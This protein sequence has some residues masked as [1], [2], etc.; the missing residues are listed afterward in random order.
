[1][2]YSSQGKQLC[3]DLFSSTLE[4]SLDPTNR[5]YKLANSL[6]WAEIERIYNGR[7]RNRHC[8]GGNKPARMVI[9]ALIIKHKMNL[10]D[11]ET[12]Q[13]ISE[14]PYMQ[15]FVGLELFTSNPI[16]DSSLFVHIRK[17][18]DVESFNEMTLAI[19]EEES[20]KIEAA[21][22]MQDNKKEDEDE[23]DKTEADDDSFI[24][25]DG[26]P[27]K[28]SIKVDATCCEVEVKYPTDLDVLNDA[29]DVSERLIDKLCKL[30]GA[31]KPRTYRKEARHK[32]LQVIKKKRKPKKL[33]R[34]G[35]KQQ[36]G[37]LNRNIQSIIGII[38]TGSSSWYD[39]LSKKEKQWIGTII[40][41]YH[42][43]K[44]MYDAGIHQCP[45]RII[46]VFQPHVR[47]IVRGKSKA[48]V[49]FGP[50]IGAC[51]VSGY[52][53]ID[54]FSWDAYNES[55]DLETHIREYYERFGYYPVKCYADRIYMNRENRALL[56]KYHIKAAGK[57]LGRPTKEMQTEAYRIQSAKDMGERNEVEATF[58]TGKRVYSVSDV[59]AKLPDTA[60]AW[61]AACFFTKNVMKFLKGL[62]LA[63]FGYVR[64]SFEKLFCKINR[65]FFILVGAVT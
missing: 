20:S 15:Y 50:K 54:R 9:G 10:S 39:F 57:P 51:V 14:N 7:L 62:L 5:W 37:Y 16:F 27:H 61:T 19:M 38:S 47:P 8:G 30:S 45:D 26:N 23:E 31:P 36:L 33:I 29:R 44:G 12:I 35:I 42:Q 4:K 46:S 53:F 43:Q 60:D 59:R 21:S 58:G 41:V 17:R 55:V 49:E 63:L 2:K 11:E 3:L 22:K 56:K 40:K 24:D 52:T 34:K 6:P 13:I 25:Q 1:M 28:G 18:I 32:F 65:R 64:L 48:K